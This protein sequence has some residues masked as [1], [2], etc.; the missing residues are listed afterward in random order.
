MK[1]S[2]RKSAVVFCILFVCLVLLSSG[3]IF[4]KHGHECI[5][6]NCNMCCLIDAAQKILGGLTLL[7]AA[8][9]ILAATVNFGVRRFLFVLKQ[10]FQSSLIS[11]KVK[12]SD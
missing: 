4:A 12:L 9:S 5:E 11:L 10:S 6:N 2:T 7:A 3:L 1:S 8:S